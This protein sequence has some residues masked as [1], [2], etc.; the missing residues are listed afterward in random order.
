MFE[1][2]LVTFDQAEK[3][4]GAE[5]LH[6]SLHRAK[7]KGEVEFT[8]N[9]DPVSNLLLAIIRNQFVPLFARKIH[10]GII[11]Q[12]SEIVLGKTGPH[13]LKIDQIGLAIAQEDV[14]RL[15]IAMHQNSRQIGETFRNLAQDGQCGE[16]R[17]LNAVNLEMA[18]QTI[19]EKI[20][21]FPKIKR[22]V[23]FGR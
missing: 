8:V 19:L 5:S 11:K 2:L 4:V 15:K 22:S 6:Q 7:A 23:E 18:A 21:L 3:S 10:I 13:S 20:I 1:K 12:R 9:V 14:L 17:E 16:R